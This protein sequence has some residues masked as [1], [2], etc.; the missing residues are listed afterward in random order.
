MN[1]VRM[2]TDAEETPATAA[3]SSPATSCRWDPHSAAVEEIL[4]LEGPLVSNRRV[5]TRSVDIGGR[6]LEAGERVSVMWIAANR[7]PAVFEDPAEFRL[8]RD[9]SASLLWG[10]GIHVCPG[11]PLARL[12]LRVV[13]EE[14]LAATDRIEP[15]PGERLERASWPAAGFERVPVR[16]VRANAAD[17]SIRCLMVGPEGA[18]W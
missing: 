5:T 9:P 1:P 12:E 2:Q 6:R 11:A 7:D 8:D 18:R 10:R 4:R 3:T 16:L 13:L 14:L 17:R 15:L